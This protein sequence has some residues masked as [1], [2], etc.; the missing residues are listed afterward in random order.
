MAHVQLCV[1]VGHLD[2]DGGL[3]KLMVG[4]GDAQQ[5][6]DRELEVGDVLHGIL[7]NGPGKR[8]R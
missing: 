4:H 6:L 8:A 5:E 3:L 2:K 7:A 1:T